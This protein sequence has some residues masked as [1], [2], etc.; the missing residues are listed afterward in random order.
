MREF[1][2]SIF[3]Q[4][5]G[6]LLTDCIRR[7]IGSKLCILVI[8]SACAVLTFLCPFA[9]RAG[10]YFLMACVAVLGLSRNSGLVVM[11]DMMAWWSP[12]S[13]K[14]LLNSFGSSGLGAAA[15]L[16]TLIAG[17]ACDIPLDNGWPFMYYI[18]G[19]IMTIFVLMW[20]VM[21]SKTPDEHPFISYDE[22]QFI[23]SHRIGMDMV[24][25]KEYVTRLEIKRELRKF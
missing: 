1:R 3:S 18:F 4:I 15:V 23:V 9:T 20:F 14:V 11:G 21:S 17:L 19:G 22:R 13:E 8:I 16:G 7:Q 10:P 6:P 5:V 2:T 12:V 24:S 25:S